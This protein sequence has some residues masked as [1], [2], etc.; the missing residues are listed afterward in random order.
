MIDR[1]LKLGEGFVAKVGLG[2][3]VLIGA[4][5]AVLA[6]GTLYLMWD[7]RGARIEALKSERLRL[8]DA[9][10]A[11]K[12]A[13][14]LQQQSAAESDRV[15]LQLDRLREEQRRDFNEIRNRVAS[16]GRATE[17]ACGPGVGLALDELRKRPGRG[18]ASGDRAS[19]GIEIPAPVPAPTRSPP[20]GPARR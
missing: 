3:L 4:G 1:L 6:I 9:N 20:A 16:V 17:V 8:V 13:L 18:G 12:I 14:V 2:K 19:G 15:Q 11:Q 10:A 5:V 7:A